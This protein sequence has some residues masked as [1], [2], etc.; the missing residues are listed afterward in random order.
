MRALEFV[1]SNTAKKNNQF[2]RFIQNAQINGNVEFRWIL[3]FV[4][5]VNYE[6]SRKLVSQD[7]ITN[8]KLFKN[9]PQISSYGYL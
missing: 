1:M 8:S 2:S 5:L 3:I 9:H 4:I 7:F 6:I